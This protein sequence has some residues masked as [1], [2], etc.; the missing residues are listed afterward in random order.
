MLLSRKSEGLGRKAGKLAACRNWR[1]QRLLAQCIAT[2]A[3]AGLFG[4]GLVAAAIP[5]GVNDIVPDGRTLTT[6]NITGHTTTISTATISGGDAFNSFQNFAISSGNTVDLIVP[7]AVNNL[8]NLVHDGPVVINGILNSYKNGQIGGNIVFADPQGILVG[9][10]GVLNVGAINFTTPTTQF[11]NQLVNQ[12]GHVDMAAASQLL[13]GTEPLSD[14]GVVSIAGRINALTSINLAAAEV[15]AAKSSVLTAGDSAKLQNALFHA[16][17]NTTG[18]QQ[19]AALAESNGSIAIVG[20]Q[21]VNLAGRVKASGTKGGIITATA[22]DTVLDSSATLDVSGASGGGTVLLGGNFHGQ[23]SLPKATNVIVNSGATILANAVLQGDGGRVALWSTLGTVFDGRIEANGG[24]NSGN[25]GYV[26]VSSPTGLVFNGHVSTSAPNGLTGTLL[27]DPTD[28]YIVNGNSGSG[29]EDSSVSNGT[30]PFTAADGSPASTIS[31][32]ELQS[33]GNTNITLEATDAITIGDS[34]GNPANVNLATDTTPLT[35]GTLTL[36]AGTT[37]AGNITFNTGSSIET[38]GGAVVLD[39]GAGF[40]GSGAYSSTGTFGTATLGAI[41][42]SGGSVTVNA[43]NNISLPASTVINTTGTGVTGAIDFEGGLTLNSGIDVNN[44]QS[45]TITIDGT[46]DGGNITLDENSTADSVYS[47]NATAIASFASS[48]VIGN[49]LNLAGQGV[50]ATVNSAV[51]IDGTAVI[52]GTNVNIESQT[53]EEASSPEYNI[54]L[55]S[56]NPF[57]SS[58]LYGQVGGTATSTVAKGATININSG[59]SLTVA[60]TNNDT[61]DL[62]AY[63]VTTTTGTYTAATVAVGYANINSNATIASGANINLAG[64]TDVNVTAHNI[65]SFSVSATAMANSQGVVGIAAA[66][67]DITTN[68]KAAEDASLGTTGQQAGNVTVVGDNITTQEATSASGSS[69]SSF[70]INTALSAL[71]SATSQLSALGTK[72]S[73]MFG[74]TGGEGGGSSASEGS[75]STTPF[76][77]GAAM[78]LA[79]VSQGSYAQIANDDGVNTDTPVIDSSGNVLV[80]AATN[81]AGIRND[82]QSAVNSATSESGADPTNPA[83]QVGVSVGVG[84]G[85][86]HQTTQA[87]IGDNV[88]VTAANVGVS[89]VSNIPA[90]ITWTQWNSFSTVLSHLNGTFGT[91]S[92]VLT[93]Y[94]N[95][96]GNATNL[97][98]AGAVNFFDVYNNTQAWIGTGAKVTST[99][100]GEASSV[101]GSTDIPA[102]S[103]GLGWDENALDYQPGGTV[104]DSTLNF[105]DP[106]TVNAYNFTQ[107]IDVGGNFSILLNGS[108]AGSSGTGVGGAFNGILYNNTTDAAIGSGAVV[109]VDNSGPGLSV[110]AQ[111]VDQLVAVA[112]TS[113]YGSSVAGNGIFGFV[114]IENSTLASIS[115]AADISA[116]Q[117]VLDGEEDLSVWNVAGAASEGNT[118]GVGIGLAISYFNTDTEAFIGDNS[119]WTLGGTTLGGTSGGG[120]VHTGELAVDALTDGQAGTLAVAGAATSSSDPNAEPGNLDKAKSWANGKLTSLQLFAAQAFGKIPAIGSKIA[121]AVGPAV[122]VQQEQSVPD[123]ET[124]I[125]VAGSFTFN[126]AELTT[127]A[128][129]SIPRFRR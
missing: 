94:A 87:D 100:T 80:H 74:S 18:L 17:V 45:G 122:S 92:D 59:G 61:L 114:D 13:S 72:L 12:A 68:A 27:L 63:T 69:G 71:S 85:I 75:S 8:V 40:S 82:A 83:N 124:S 9:A 105:N 54:S 47:T 16:T 20:T 15:I 25:G 89:A 56:F 64:D 70:V 31:V 58:I 3:A 116:D 22:P 5:A 118:T 52:T 96:S 128:W 125:G 43:A 109:T 50:L 107:S 1:R 88:Q 62:S 112:P 23:G 79:L 66:I 102:W 93:S 49:I 21:Q 103:V 119:T 115:N 98:I 76:R 73:S 33:L 28:L 120:Y 77:V 7:A 95:A 55:S 41:T 121:S 67:S 32:G 51:N 86:Y 104:A 14:S 29:T 65:N 10:S 78:G 35:T 34:S 99:A 117:V 48:S 101:S 126:V 113:G 90:T 110:T 36:E 37:G 19:G 46:L 127:K 4:S 24:A 2:G 129:R 84:V 57:P 123:S 106:I 91:A 39:A 30:L 53:T 11:L 6:V 111:G 38:A 44:S 97:S 26:E 42:T 108:G 60:A 81:T